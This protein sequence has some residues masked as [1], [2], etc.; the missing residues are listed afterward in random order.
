M[1]RNKG[2]CTLCGKGAK[3][4]FEHVPAEGS[5]NQRDVIMYGLEEW[6]ARDSVTGELRGGTPQPEGMGLPALCR[7][8]NVDLLGSHYVPAFIEF[9]DAGKQMLSSLVGRLPE[10]DSS[11][12]ATELAVTFLA[13][14]RLA[15]VK[16]IVS[17]ILVTSGRGVV[18]ANPALEEFV[19]APMARGLPTQYRLF[20]ALCAGPVAK[21]T[22]LSVRVN[23]AAETHDLI[24]EVVYPPFAYALSFN[25]TAAYS[26]GEISDWA[27]AAYG[28]VAKCDLR[29]PLGFCHTAFPGD[30]RTRAQVER[31][32]RENQAA[33][34]EREPEDL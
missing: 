7:S 26:T 34:S 6:L 29:L 31:T 4:T 22:G 5:G 28:E 11:D 21:T 13:V 19:R 30:L 25:G 2:I 8:C 15:V 32:V 18:E 16:Q 33:L 23:P 9:V 10:F 20:L 12:R 24:S 27:D 17:M 3:L 1:G 14:N